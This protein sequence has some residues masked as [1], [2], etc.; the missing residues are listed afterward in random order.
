[1]AMGVPC[2]A[3]RSWPLPKNLL[4]LWH[5][6]GQQ[7]VAASGKRRYLKTRSFSGKVDFNLSR[8]YKKRARDK[9]GSD[10]T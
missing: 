3:Q 8:T 9:L 10:K 6:L 2:G 7:G 5:H 4:M 1:M